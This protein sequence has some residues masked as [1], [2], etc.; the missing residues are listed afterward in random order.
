MIDNDA[1][2]RWRLEYRTFGGDGT[3]RRRREWFHRQEALYA[4][5]YELSHV[6][7]PCESIFDVRIHRNNEPYSPH[8]AFIAALESLE[9]RGDDDT[10]N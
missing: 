4:R 7:A 10:R 9:R 5:L 8:D 1:I 2:F 3:T 6:A